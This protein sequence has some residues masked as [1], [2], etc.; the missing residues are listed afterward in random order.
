MG[1][2]RD[3]SATQKKACWQILILCIA[4][5]NFKIFY[6]VMIG[7]KDIFLIFMQRFLIYKC[8]SLL[9][10]LDYGILFWGFR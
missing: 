2:E 5:M 6:S 9:G 10:P 3:A 4:N 7:K 8:F 1:E